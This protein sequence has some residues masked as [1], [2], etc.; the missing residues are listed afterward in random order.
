MCWW[1]NTICKPPRRIRGKKVWRLQLPRRPKPHL[2]TEWAIYY[3]ANT[4]CPIQRL[5]FEVKNKKLIYFFK[6]QTI[7][8]VQNSLGSLKHCLLTEEGKI[9][10]LPNK[11]FLLIANKNYSICLRVF[12]IAECIF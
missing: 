8:Q 1:I 2:Q 9:L 12:E 4:T 3:L 10:K 6:F 11:T 5:S 7:S